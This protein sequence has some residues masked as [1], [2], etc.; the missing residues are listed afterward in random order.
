MNKPKITL[1][2]PVWNG[3]KTIA[4]TIASVRLQQPYCTQYI[5]LDSESNDG[6]AELIRANMDTVTQ[7]VR[8][9]DGGLYDA[10][11]KGI[12]LATG[13]IVGIINADDMLISGALKMV[14]EAFAD[15]LVDFVYSDVEVFDDTGQNVGVFKARPDWVAGATSWHGRDWRFIVPLSHPSLFVRRRVYNQ[16]GGFDLK[17]RLAA[18][19][20]FIARLIARGRVGR[21]LPQPLSRFRIGGLSGSDFTIFAEDEIIARRYGVPAWLAKLNRFRSVL[22]R[23]KQR[24]LQIPF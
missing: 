2:T 8:E 16:I 3:V 1:I 9:K 15:P 18:D 24:T 6:T 22:G 19:H 21:Y 17:F 12:Q 13:E 14:A 23:I 10:M 11:N 4:E 5:V 20:E 7:Y